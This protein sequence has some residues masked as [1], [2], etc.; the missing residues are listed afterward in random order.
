M[1]LQEIRS[2]QKILSYNEVLTFTEA[3]QQE[4]DIL[5]PNCKCELLLYT[6]LT[7]LE[8]QRMSMEEIETYYD[9][10]QKV[11]SLTL[12]KERLLTD[13]RIQ[14]RLG[15]MDQVDKL[16]SQRNVINSQIRD[17]INELPTDEM[18]KKVVAINR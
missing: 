14:K 13:T 2:L 5:H 9:I 10:R 18:K 12:K 16:N 3:E 7:K 11:N 17:L 1:R 15:N 4:G 6:P 8:R